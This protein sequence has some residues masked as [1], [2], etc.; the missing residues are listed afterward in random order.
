MAYWI[1]C[2]CCDWS[3]ITFVLFYDPQ[4]KNALSHLYICY[5]GLRPHAVY[6]RLKRSKLDVNREINAATFHVPDAVKVYQDYFNFINKAKSA[7]RGRGL[8][9]DIHGQE[10]NLE[11]V[12]L[13]YLLRGSQLNKDV[14]SVEKTSIRNLGKYWCGRHTSCLKDFIRGNRSLGHFMNQEGLRTL[15]SPQEPAPNKTSYFTGGYTVKWYGSRFGGD[16]DAIQME[17]PIQLRTKVGWTNA[18]SRV[19]RAILHFLKL[20]YEN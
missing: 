16:I 12:E 18:R 19:V 20:N 5:I 4:I 17:F 11:R 8:L 15:P 1:V 10:H 9:L 2:V 7:I 14:F 3:V 13:G 6:N